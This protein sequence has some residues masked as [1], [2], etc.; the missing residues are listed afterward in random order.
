MRDLIP[1]REIMKKVNQEVIQK[2]NL[3]PKFSAN[4]KFMILF[5]KRKKFLFVN[6]EFMR[7]MQLVLRLLGYQDLLLELNILQYLTIS[8]ELQSNKWKLQPN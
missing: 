2:N 1:L 7:T 6:L 5:Q 4:S 8:S 3:I